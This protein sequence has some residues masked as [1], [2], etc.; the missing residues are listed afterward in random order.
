MNPRRIILLIALLLPVLSWGQNTFVKEQLIKAEE[1]KIA[2]G[3]CPEYIDV[4]FEAREIAMRENDK[5]VTIKICE[6]LLNAVQVVYPN[7]KELIQTSRLY[8]A[9]MCSEVGDHEKALPLLKDC[10]SV[11]KGKDYETEHVLLAD[12]VQAYYSLTKYDDA[13]KYQ[14]IL[15]SLTLKNEGKGYKYAG[16]LF[17]IS[18]FYLE[19]QNNK[20]A[21]RVLKE[22]LDILESANIINDRLYNDT[23]YRYELLTTGSS[24][25]ESERAVFLK[26]YE[27]IQRFNETNDPAYIEEAIQYLEDKDYV[28][29]IDTLRHHTLDQ[30]A[31][32]YTENGDYNRALD[33][34][35]KEP[36]WDSGN[37]F[38]VGRAE[39]MLGRFSDA[40]EGYK[41]AFA[42]AYLEK[43]DVSNSYFTYFGFYAQNCI[44]T[45]QYQEVFSL[46]EQFYAS[47]AAIPGY[48]LRAALY[49]STLAELKFS[50]NDYRGTI[51]CIKKCA[52]VF[53][54]VDAIDEYARMVLLSAGCYEQLGDYSACAQEMQKLLDVYLAYPEFIDSIPS[55]EVT[56]A[57]Y[58]G[59]AGLMDKAAESVEQTIER[60][61]THSFSDFWAESV[62]H[63]AL[64]HYYQFCGDNV[65]AEK[66]Y[67]NGTKILKKNAPESDYNYPQQLAALGLLYLQWPHNEHKALPVFEEAFNLIKKYHDPSYALYF[68]FYE[69]LLAAK[70]ASNTPIS[71]A[72]IKDFVE[73]EKLQAQ[74]LLF[75]MSETEREAFWKSHN[76]VK[77]LVFSL[78]ETQSVPS[79]LYDYALL[80]KGLLLNSSK[81]IG[82]IVMQAD[83]ADLNALYGR[84][85]V[86][87]QEKETKDVS[88]ETIDA[89]EH[90]ILSRCHTLGYSINESFSFSDVAASIGDDSVAIEFVDYE[91]LE[92]AADKDGE[93]KYIAL[94]LKKGWDEPKLI[95]LCTSAELEKVISD[96][97]KAYEGNALF[98][99]VWKPLESYLG[100]VKNVYYSPSGLI[101]QVA[102]EAIPFGK[103]KILSD[104]YSLVR[105]SST[106]VLCGNNTDLSPYVSSAVYGGLQ[107]S[108]SDEDILSNSQVYSY[109]STPTSDDYLSRGGDTTSPWRFLPGT[110]AEAEAVSSILSSGN[111]SST[112]YT[113]AAGNEESFKSLSGQSPSILHIATHGF[114]LQNKDFVSSVAIAS[115]VK[116]QL[117]VQKSALKRSGL[118]MAGANPAWTEGRLLPNVEDGVLTAEEISRLDLRNTSLAI[119]SACDS[120]LGEINNDGVEGLQRAFKAAGVN[121]LVVTLWKVDDA[122]TELMMTEFYKNLMEGHPRREAFDMARVS[123][124]KKY[125]EPYY[126][127]PFVM[128]D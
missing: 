47:D 44:Q 29:N 15:N 32:Y 41:Q 88:L 81:Q 68:A 20:E 24:S 70:Y 113:G 78:K 13:I 52:P 45:G 26:N 54:G 2:K 12:I 80:Y 48:E 4:L 25:V 6:D 22:A 27:L 91:Q 46:L 1:I 77:N 31:F 90:Q 10:Y 112:L 82:N 117:Q 61:S 98:N 92:G 38:H 126:W 42:H 63:N 17:W 66:E 3:L 124:K 89:M 33:V 57:L 97:Y 8:L 23:R 28:H 35:L 67:L 107:Y 14:K 120:G 96:K 64:G 62:Y 102:L 127:A 104:R 7:E 16:G 72:E 51:E 71:L 118:I 108:L 21:I 56:L 110:R 36:Y 34:M 74:S 105:L 87:S 30:L 79:F 84:Y 76:D 19:V 99:L 121:T 85:L 128:I 93:I 115:G 40:K 5:T 37:W 114:Y 83:D 18:N 111:I 58:S 125:P 106:R 39:E 103:G 122:S 53:L 11:V 95:S 100:G 123:V 86:L 65:N 43:K 94:L 101:H 69:G 119:I 60:F 73:V 9:L 59:Q 55:T 50:I 109:R 116:D 49:M 75:Q